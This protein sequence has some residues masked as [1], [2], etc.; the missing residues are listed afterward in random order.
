MLISNIFTKH[1]SLSFLT[2]TWS[3]SAAK[4]A[5]SWANQCKIGHDPNTNGCGQNL[6]VTLATYKMNSSWPAGIKVWYSEVSKFTYGAPDKD[7]SGTGHYTQ[8][9]WARSNTVGCGFAQCKNATLKTPH[10][11]VHVCN[12]CPA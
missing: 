5:Q 8:V 11:S 7:V 1:E 2:Q 12:Y 6:H 9:V 10:Y 3:D 4:T